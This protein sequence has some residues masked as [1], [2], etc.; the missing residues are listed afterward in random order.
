[1]LYRVGQAILGFVKDR[2]FGQEQAPLTL[3]E[4][5]LQRVWTP[6]NVRTWSRSVSFEEMLL[7][8]RS[9]SL[10]HAVLL[11]VS[12][13]SFRGDAIGHSSCSLKKRAPFWPYVFSRSAG[14][15]FGLGADRAFGIAARR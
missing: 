2:E 14:T 1:M 4:M 6:S 8:S 7:E 10:P 15:L 13:S 3:W 12:G 11:Q 9:G 5:L